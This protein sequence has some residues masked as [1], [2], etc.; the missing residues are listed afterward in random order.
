MRQVATPRHA[1]LRSVT[2]REKDDVED[3]VEMRAGE[4][5]SATRPLLSPWSRK[6]SWPLWG[7]MALGLVG[8]TAV[9]ALAF[10][11][12]PSVSATIRGAHI[13]GVPALPDA[14][15]AA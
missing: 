4:P 10:W 13:P 2:T 9:V 11:L 7:T 1:Q 14:I 15:N 3:G 5:A 12:L 6:R 8:A